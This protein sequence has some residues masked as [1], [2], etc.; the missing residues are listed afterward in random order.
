MFSFACCSILRKCLETVKK[1]KAKKLSVLGP[2]L[3]KVS[4]KKVCNCIH[5]CWES[6]CT[7]FMVLSNFI[8]IQNEP[9]NLLFVFFFFFNLIA[10]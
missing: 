10:Y 3:N 6:N 5:I 8:R 4:N 7:F 9:A 1:P 2:D